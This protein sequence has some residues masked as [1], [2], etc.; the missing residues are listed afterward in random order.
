MTRNDGTVYE[1]EFYGGER[2]GQVMR[3]P[4]FAITLHG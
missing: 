3:A 2:H 4:S 1:G